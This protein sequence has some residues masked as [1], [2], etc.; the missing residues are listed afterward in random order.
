MVF[1]QEM[2][3]VM[4]SRH[5]PRFSTFED[6]CCKA[7]NIIRRNGRLFISLFAM[8]VPA[9][10]PELTNAHDVTY[11]EEKLSLNLTEA[12]AT[13]KFKHEI[14]NALSSHSRRIDNW[15][16]SIRHGALLD[17]ASKSM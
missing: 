8:M 6:M 7:Y 5:G 17:K 11:M 16:H 4:G 14:R 9:G 13:K 12:A 10:V 15:M 1:T 2:A 3:F